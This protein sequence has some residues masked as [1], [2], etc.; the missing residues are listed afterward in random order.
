[1]GR[2]G[3]SGKGWMCGER[4]SS[5]GACVYV[6]VC[7]CVCVCA[8]ACVW[9]CVYACRVP[10]ALPCTPQPGTTPTRASRASPPPVQP[11]QKKFTK[12]NS[13]EAKIMQVRVC[14][15][16]CV[17]LHVCVCVCV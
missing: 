6:C 12:P 17:R 4:R 2:V 10:R 1:M 14:A 16:A 3:A 9:F 13:D 8:C 15:L 11:P 5:G 7:V